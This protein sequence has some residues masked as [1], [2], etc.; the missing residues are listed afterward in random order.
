MRKLDKDNNTSNMI[1]TIDDFNYSKPM[2]KV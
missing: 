2:K 1:D